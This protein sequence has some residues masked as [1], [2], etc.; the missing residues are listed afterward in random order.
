[1][2]CSGAWGDHLCLHAAAELFTANIHIYTLRGNALHVDILR[3]FHSPAKCTFK[4]A[5]WTGLHFESLKLQARVPPIQDE[6]PEEKEEVIADQVLEQELMQ[7]CQSK[8]TINRITPWVESEADQ[9]E[10]IQDTITLRS[11]VV[12]AYFVITLMWIAIMNTFSIHSQLKIGRSN[13][14][15]LIFL[16]VVGA[17]IAIQFVLMV[18]HR[19]WTFLTS[20]IPSTLIFHKTVQIR[21]PVSDDEK[22]G[23]LE[24]GREGVDIQ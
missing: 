12:S 8:S 18:M 13:A 6:A 17:T 4:L 16:C 2:R 23:F 20:F 10:K 14:V 22:R 9:K 24:E 21:L 15:G 5:Y 1:M 3:P 11:K 7:P 19:V